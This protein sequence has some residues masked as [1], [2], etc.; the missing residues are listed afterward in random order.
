MTF[1][2]INVIAT[3]SMVGIKLQRKMHKRGIDNQNKFLFL[4][5]KIDQITVYPMSFDEFLMNSN[6]MLYDTI[7]M[8]YENK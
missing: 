4:V 2:A 6:K 8:A 3:G 5:G 1:G 7:K